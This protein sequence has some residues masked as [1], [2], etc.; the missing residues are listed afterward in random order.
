MSSIVRELGRKILF[1][2]FE[3]GL[4]TAQLVDNLA[5]DGFELGV[6]CARFLK[7]SFEICL[8]LGEEAGFLRLTILVVCLGHSELF[9]E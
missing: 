4:D 7:T 2:T 3:I 8:L 9:L 5:V 1:S 6:G